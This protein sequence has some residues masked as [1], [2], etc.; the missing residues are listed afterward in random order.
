M[1]CDSR[2]GEPLKEREARE[3]QGGGA[4]DEEIA[5]LKEALW[6][7]AVWNRGMQQARG[8]R[9]YTQATLPSPSCTTAPCTRVEGLGE[10]AGSELEPSR[11]SRL[12]EGA[13]SDLL[14]TLHNVSIYGRIAIDSTP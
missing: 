10:T 8:G 13:R 3:L 6:A 11:K 14:G 12:G 4:G 2:E 5:A 7:G 9:A 1:R